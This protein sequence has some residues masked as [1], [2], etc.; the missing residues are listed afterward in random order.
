MSKPVLVF[1]PKAVIMNKKAA[2]PRAAPI[3]PC[4]NGFTLIEVMIVVAIVAILAAVALPSYRNYVMRGRVP[5]ATSGLASQRVK[6]EQ[7]YQDNQ[8]YVGATCTNTATTVTGKY[9]GFTCT[10]AT[11]SA[12]LLTAQGTGAMS[13][14]SFTIDQDGNR[15]STVAGV[16]G[17]SS[18]SPNNC[19]VTNAGGIC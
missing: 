4:A 5:E 9:F 2:R 3:R 17:W 14:F 12:Y 11:A 8:T 19:W 7:W 6:M 16:S 18:P 10:S 13:G 15:A 1:S